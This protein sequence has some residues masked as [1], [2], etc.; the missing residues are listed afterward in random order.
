MFKG[1]TRCDTGRG[2]LLEGNRVRNTPGWCGGNRFNW[3]SKLCFPPVVYKMPNCARSHMIICN[4]KPQNFNTGLKWC[5][6]TCSYIAVC[7]LGGFLKV[8]HIKTT[9]IHVTAIKWGLNQIEMACPKSHTSVLKI[10]WMHECVKCI[11]AENVQKYSAHIRFECG[12]FTP[13][14]NGLLVT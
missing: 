3:C 14:A 4:Y 6:L 13:S 8:S 7:S 1:R 9:E 2:I 5:S 11:Y 12:H 10:F